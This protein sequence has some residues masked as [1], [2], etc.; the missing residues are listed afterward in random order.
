MHFPGMSTPGPHKGGCCQCIPRMRGAAP[1]QS[2]EPH[3]AWGRWGGGG[4]ARGPR[5][6]FPGAVPPALHDST[7]KRLLQTDKQNNRFPPASHSG[8]GS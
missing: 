3:V 1:T 8:W 7:R 2:R 5:V 4:G 6:L